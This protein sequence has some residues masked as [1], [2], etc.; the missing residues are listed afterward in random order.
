MCEH[1]LKCHINFGT[2]EVV[3][4]TSLRMKLVN[5]K[6]EKKGVVSTHGYRQMR[7]EP[8]FGSEP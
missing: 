8:S 2:G 6:R 1:S 5:T 7:I 4:L 3:L